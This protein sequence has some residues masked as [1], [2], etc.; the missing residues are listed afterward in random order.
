[1]ADD[2]AS[3][4]NGEVNTCQRSPYFDDEGVISLSKGERL[5]FKL[6]KFNAKLLLIHVFGVS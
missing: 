4:G 6:P 1:M 5:E 3:N 2:K